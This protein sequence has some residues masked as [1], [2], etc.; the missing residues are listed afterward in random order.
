[1]W[2]VQLGET[3]LFHVISDIITKDDR[4]YT[5]ADIHNVIGEVK[6]DLVTAKIFELLHYSTER[7]VV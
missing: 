4:L 5:S 6:T 7:W 2:T 3:E 1:M